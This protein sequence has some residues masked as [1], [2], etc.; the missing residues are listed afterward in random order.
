MT[1]IAI[2]DQTRAFLACQAPPV[3]EAELNEC[4]SILRAD[5]IQSQP[6][7]LRSLI[8]RTAAGKLVRIQFRYV[9]WTGQI[10]VRAAEAVSI[11]Y[12]QSVSPKRD[13]QI[14]GEV[15]R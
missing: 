13:R 8:G 9:T 2:D 12:V 14:H 10:Y 3:S 11:P 6:N 15:A 1:Q 5:T 7:K 4:F